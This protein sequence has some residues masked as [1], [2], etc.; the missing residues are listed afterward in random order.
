MYKAL[1]A[2]LL[3]VHI[4]FTHSLQFREVNVLWRI[5]DERVHAHLNGD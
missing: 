4:L 5:F 3:H 2:M 1:N